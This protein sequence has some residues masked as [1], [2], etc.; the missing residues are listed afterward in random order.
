MWHNICY[1][2]TRKQTCGKL[3]L[4][5]LSRFPPPDKAVSKWTDGSQRTLGELVQ[6]TIKYAK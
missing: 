3:D 1:K 2:N 6:L 5:Q 4:C